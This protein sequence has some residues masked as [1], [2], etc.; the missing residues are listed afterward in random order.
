MSISKKDVKVI[1]VVGKSQDGSEILHVETKGGLH[2][3][4]KRRKKGDFQLLGH[5]NHRGVARVLSNQFEK[6]IQ[7]HESLFK[8]EDSEYLK[9]YEKENRMVPEST[10]ANHIAQAVWHSYMHQNG[11]STNRLY[12]GLQAISHYQAAGLD[13]SRALEAVN[14]TLKK[15]NKSYSMDKPFDEELLK[16]AYEKKHNKPFPS[17]E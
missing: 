15:L 11:D 4:F 17:G 16:F 3:M 9:Q 10:S 12:H 6:N 5:G 13:K 14:N 1:E 8:S 7:W 2:Q